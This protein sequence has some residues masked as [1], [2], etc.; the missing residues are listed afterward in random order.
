MLALGLT[1]TLLAAAPAPAK[2]P[3][4]TSEA[5]ATEKAKMLFSWAQRLYKQARYAEAISKF[6]EAYSLRPHPVIYFNLGRCYEQLGEVPRAMRAYKDYLRLLPDAQDKEMVSDAIVNLERRLKEQGVQ[7][8]MVFAEPPTAHI[9]VDGKGLGTSP[10][11]VELRAGNHQLRVSADGFEPSERSLVMSSGHSTEMTINLR[12]RA[13]PVAERSAPAADAPLKAVLTPPS[14]PPP[15]VAE[16]AAEPPRKARVFTWVAGGVAVAGLGTGVGLG[17]MANGKA[18]DYRAGGHT[19]LE[20]Q[21]LYDGARGFATGA[22]VAYG[23]A[24][25]A[26]IT[27][28]V[29]FFVE[30]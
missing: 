8:L 15:V 5:A 16:V 30:R 19:Q 3:P 29:L 6:E 28:A 4:P 20:T 27:A 11:S 21:A 10:A 24:A 18:A 14:P 13:A 26:A 9:E 23:V 7:Q 1:L 25:G 22:N 17:L 12:P 2:A